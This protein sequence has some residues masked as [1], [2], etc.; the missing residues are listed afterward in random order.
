MVRGR[1]L[2]RLTRTGVIAQVRVSRS[3]LIIEQARY[4]VQVSNLRQL[5]GTDLVAAERAAENSGKVLQ[6]FDELEGQMRSDHL[7]V[8]HPVAGDVGRP[9][10]G[11]AILP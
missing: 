11:M 1:S 10:E 9:P 4:F 2:A 3:G 5:L 7:H 8:L 6:A